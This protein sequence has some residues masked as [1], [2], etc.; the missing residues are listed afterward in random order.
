MPSRVES[1]EAGSRS[2]P[3]RAHYWLHELHCG[4]QGDDNERTEGAGNDNV[5]HSDC[6][7]MPAWDERG[8]PWA[9]LCAESG[10]GIVHEKVMQCHI[11]TSQHNVFSELVNAMGA[12][13]HV[14]H[15]LVTHRSTNL[16]CPERGFYNE[17]ERQYFPIDGG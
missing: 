6:F 17:A 3:K 1:T 11:Q 2:L 15:H 12:G 7:G 4:R 5:S 16:P 9:A 10:E 8:S 14:P 13:S